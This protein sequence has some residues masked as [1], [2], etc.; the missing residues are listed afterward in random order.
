MGCNQLYVLPYSYV[1]VSYA[2]NP[3][4]SL[5]AEECRTIETEGS[6]VLSTTCGRGLLVRNTRICRR[7]YVYR[8]T[9][10]L[11]CQFC[12]VETAAD[13]CSCDIADLSAV[14]PD[15][16]LVIDA[17]EKKFESLSAQHFVR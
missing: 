2:R 8:Q 17:V 15:V 13:E 1:S 3:V 11:S 14:Q 7:I 9:V 10:F 12:D 5:R 4:P 6:S 16:R